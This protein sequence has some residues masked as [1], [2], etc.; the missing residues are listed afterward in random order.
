[1]KRQSEYFSNRLSMS[2]IN[3]LAELAALCAT[4]QMASTTACDRA[5]TF[6]GPPKVPIS[7]A[8]NAVVGAIK[9]WQNPAKAQAVLDEYGNSFDYVLE[10]ITC[11][12]THKACTKR[13]NCHA[14]HLFRC[15]RE[16]LLK[17]VK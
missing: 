5:W 16:E 12:R 10:H 9:L 11:L 4:Q 6:L 1:M 2:R 17:L 13:C 14:C 3:P 7:K 15:A 8:S